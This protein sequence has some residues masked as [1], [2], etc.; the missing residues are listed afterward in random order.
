VYRE[1]TDERAN[2]VAERAVTICNTPDTRIQITAEN[3]S[4]P[5]L[6]PKNPL[7]NELIV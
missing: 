7:T 5:I 1:I 6:Y 3:A 2:I 4:L